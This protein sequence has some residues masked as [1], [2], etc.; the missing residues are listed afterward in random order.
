MPSLRW[1]NDPGRKAP[2]FELKRRL[3]SMG[4]AAN[5]DIALSA[6]GVDESHALIQFDGQRFILQCLAPS[7]DCRVNGKRVRRQ[8]LEHEDLVELGDAQLTF[9]L[10]DSV[11]PETSSAPGQQDD[12]YRQILAFSRQLLDEREVRALLENMLDAII[13]LSAADKGFVLLRDGEGFTPV[14]VQQLNADELDQT[15]D[16]YSDSIVN[17]VISSRKPL[18]VSDAL[19]DDTFSTSRSVVNLKL[20]S[21]MCVPLIYRNDLLGV[22]YV[23]NDNVVNLFTEKHL[24]A[25]EVFAAQAAL[26]VKNALAYD[27]LR[28][29]RD[30]LQERLETLRFG[31]LIGACDAMQEVFEKVEKIA[32]ADISVLIT[33]ETGTGK[34]LIARELHER[35]ARSKGPFIT[36]N[37]G[38]IPPALLESEL[39]GHVKGAF[40]GA[41]HNRE[42]HFQAASGGTLFLDEIGEMPLNLQVKILRALQERTVSRVGATKPEQVDIRVIAATNRDLAKEVQEQ[43]FREDL[44]YRLNVVELRLPPLRERGDDVVLIAQ[45]LLERYTR[46]FQVSKRTLTADALAA[47]RRFRWPGN[48]RQLENH[49]KKAVVLADTPR[50]RAADLDLPDEAGHHIEAL[51]DAKEKWQRAYIA[52]AVQ[53]HGGNRSEAARELGIDPRTIYRYL[54][55]GSTGNDA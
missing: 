18:I 43:R 5:S 13:E 39:F 14:A 6:P 27:E 44:Y 7:G 9:Q 40:T 49:L 45:Y 38:A 37:C 31:T 47:I 25:L 19:R 29:E 41:T 33:G 20:C 35:S 23:G 10:F 1:Q 54:G 55:G 46:E 53:L 15:L 51:S 8:A 28:L 2:S 24:E 26:I 30:K 22:I 16:G 42:G 48:I 52:R 17:A 34:E 21:V 50:I 3:T 32:P 36:I 11:A 4:S 12:V